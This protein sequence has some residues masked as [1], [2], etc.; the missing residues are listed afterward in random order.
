MKYPGVV[1]ASHHFA[2]VAKC[3]A[4]LQQAKH[5]LPVVKSLNLREYSIIV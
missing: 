2:C 3:L 5:C 1:T 4:I